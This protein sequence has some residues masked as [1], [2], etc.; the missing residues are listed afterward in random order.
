MILPKLAL[1]N[2][3]GAGMKTWLNAIV[4]SLAFVA[5]IWSQ[6]LYE[7]MDS[8]M[9]RIMI[10]AEY[11]GGQYWAASYDPFD[12]FSIQD[13]HAAVPEALQRQVEAGRATP[14]LIVP[15]TI[16]PNGKIQSVLLKGI[17]PIQKLLTIPAGAL[18]A[19]AGEIPGLIGSR[20]AKTT[21]LGKGDVVTVRWRDARGTFDAREVTIV[22]TMSTLAQTIDE[23][24]IWV[25]LEI[26]RSLAAMEGQA[27]I[28]VTAKG[29]K[30]GPSVSGWAFQDLDTLLAEV[31]ALV[32]SKKIGSSVMYVILLFLAVLAIFNT[33]LLSIWRRRKEIGTM[34]AMGLPRGRLVAL[35]TLEGGMTGVLAALIGA[36]YGI[37]LFIVMARRGLG[38]GDSMGDDFGIALG[39]RL[40]PTYST[41]LVVG[42]TMLVCFVATIVSYLP[43]RKIAR[44]K[45]TD[46]L[47]GKLK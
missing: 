32:R 3:L 5:I 17:D 15:G 23:G 14:I 44:L 22:E 12:P 30:R 45:P 11:G 27:T 19:S 9:S 39:S 25:P 6:G 7:G 29:A 21:G 13:A 16:Y 1:R 20:M 37:P 36:V 33:Q 26:L 47:R 18:E 42:T 24:Q 35:F 28:V 2:M 40:Y 4:L 34:M 41:A 38:F 31:K 43:S 46:A 10:D 8:Q